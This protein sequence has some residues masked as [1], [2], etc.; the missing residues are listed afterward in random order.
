MKKITFNNLSKSSK[1]QAMVEFVIILPVMLTLI[2]AIIQFSLIYKA[3]ITLNY[4][5]FEAARAG[6]INNASLEDMHLAFASGMAPL[7]TTSYQKIDS[8]G[9]CSSTF[10]SSDS[11]REARVGTEKITGDGFRGVLDANIN[12]FNSD[13]VI[14]GRRI[15]Q[16]QIEDGY[17]RISVVNPSADSFS[18]FGVTDYHDVDGEGDIKEVTLIPNDNLMYRDPSLVG[19]ASS[20]QSI[21]DANLLK[22]HVGYCYELVIPFIN[23]MVWAMQQYGPGNAPDTEVAVGNYWR[24]PSATPPGFF[25][26]PDGDFATS[27]I[28][29]PTD[30]GRRSIVLYSQSIM[31]M[32]SPAVECK[33]TDPNT[34]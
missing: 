22:V 32:Q 3:K 16:E 33:L 20:S 5:T 26:P 1:A 27:C 12:N 11:A 8:S 25:G 21:Q 29:N 28:T 15:V 17:V 30:N 19:A 2:L 9:D 23:R 7:Y 18:N 24:D 6:T 31:R 10:S 14:C 34:C 4:A 13:S